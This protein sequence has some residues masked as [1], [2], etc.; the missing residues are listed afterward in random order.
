MSPCVT[1]NFRYCASATTPTIVH[2]SSFSSGASV[3]PSLICRFWLRGMSADVRI[4]NPK[5]EQDIKS[6]K[7]CVAST[8][9]RCPPTCLRA[10]CRDKS[11][12]RIGHHFSKNESV[13]SKCSKYPSFHFE[14]SRSSSRPS[15][16]P[17]E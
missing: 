10:F 1:P 17:N 6:C 7:Q 14:S 15:A 12:S 5:V 3:L 8:A 16:A 9:I 13:D 4:H 11:L 2:H